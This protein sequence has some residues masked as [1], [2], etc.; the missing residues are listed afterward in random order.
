MKQII[1]DASGY[2]LLGYNSTQAPT[3]GKFHEIKVRV[4]RRGVDV[5][6]RKGYW[7]Y[8]LEDVARATRAAEARAPSAVTSALNAIAEPPRG[9]AARFWIGTARGD[10][11]HAAR[12]VRLGADAAG[13][14]RAAAPKAAPARVM[15]TATAPGRPAGVPRPVPEDGAPAAAPRAAAAAAGVGR[16]ARRRCERSFDAP[17][18]QLQLRM[19]VEN[20]RGPG[21]GLGD[22]GADGSGLLEGAGLV[23]HAAR[24]TRAR[25]VPRAADA[26][27]ERRRRADGG[28]RVQP[29]SGCCVRVDAYSA[30]G[31]APA[32]DRPA[33][34]PR[35]HAMADIPVQAAR[36]T[37][38]GD[39]SWRCRRSR[40]A[41]T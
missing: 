16:R 9:R 22:A 7:A 8:T 5:R 36:R 29:R 26:Q 23:R 25:T 3:D 13:D 11:R 24:A 19:V 12:H 18:G 30:D 27:G 17:P 20:S 31:V 35:R 14:A 4:K 1:R 32:V 15:L 38:S 21:D 10:E 41:T 39:W 34:Q 33:P 6:A 37:A 40:P 2:Y 28:A